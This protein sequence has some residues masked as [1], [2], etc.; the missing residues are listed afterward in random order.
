MTRPLAPATSN[1]VGQKVLPLA[2]LLRLDIVGDPLYS[3]TGIGPLYFA[4]GS[5]G[6]PAI[7]DITFTGRGEII[8][9]SNISEGKGGSDVLELSLAG[10]SLTDPML[11]QLIFNHNRWQ[12]KPAYLWGAALDPVTNEV[13]GKPFRLKTGRIDKM[14]YDENKGQGI[15][16]CQIES[17]QSYGKQPLGTRYSEARDLDP[18][19]NSQ[20]YVYSL[21]NINP[22]FGK[23][24][25]I[26][27]PSYYGD[28]S[29]GFNNNGGYREN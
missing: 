12:F 24:S 10:V 4:P 18:N 28:Y 11:R 23:A 15:V 26:N 6:D 8:G 20:D 1:A 13:V 9:M 21:A 22:E 2:F 19:D 16:K 27:N 14:P 25:A 3:W 5:I 29:G 17:Q 7:E